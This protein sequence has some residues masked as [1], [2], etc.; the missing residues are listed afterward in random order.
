MVSAD[1]EIA[2]SDA[3]AFHFTRGLS[4]KLGRKTPTPEWALS[5]EKLRQVVIAYLEVRF[6]IWPQ[7]GATYD[8]RIAAI[9]KASALRATTY[10]EHV[11]TMLA[12]YRTIEADRQQKFAT[13]IQNLDT[14]V[15][16]ADRLVEVVLHAVYLSYRLNY[17]SVQVAEA[18][19]LKP[20]AVRALLWRLRK[21]WDWL[22]T[23]GIR[24]PHGGRGP[25]KK[26]QE[27]RCHEKPQG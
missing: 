13:E 20:P 9:R 2:F 26:R 22:S 19:G 18:T 5:D 11:R 8:D 15:V 14:Q 24:P 4:P 17:N 12:A 1:T 21:T 23:T 10:R 27:G 7:P 6:Y 16:L 3:S 25:A